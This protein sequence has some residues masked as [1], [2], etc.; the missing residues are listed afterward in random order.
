[1]RSLFLLFVSFAAQASPSDRRPAAGAADRI[2][3][4]REHV[5][6]AAEVKSL[7]EHADRLLIAAASDGKSSR[8]RRARALVALRFAPS[9][10]SLAFLR[11]VIDEK[12]SFVEGAEVLELAAAAGSLA[13]YGPEALPDLLPLVTHASADVRHS[14]AQTLGSV[15]EVSGAPEAES[16]LRARLYVE[17]DPGVR[18]AVARALKI[19]SK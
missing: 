13:P 3:G 7:G 1:M 9:S 14:V 16:A 8:W 10:E 17:R 6:T 4:A 2:L 19:L 5:I 15:Y 11:A 18:D 12:K